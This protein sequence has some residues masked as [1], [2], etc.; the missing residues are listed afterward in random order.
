M[1]TSCRT[2][3]GRGPG[4]RGRRSRRGGRQ[5]NGKGFVTPCAART[6]VSAA[7][8]P[9]SPKVAAAAKVVRVAVTLAPVGRAPLARAEVSDV[10]RGGRAVMKSPNVE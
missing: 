8:T 6:A 10:V 9:S 7:G 4:H 3:Y 5:L 1:R 2:P